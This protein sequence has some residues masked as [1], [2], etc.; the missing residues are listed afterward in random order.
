MFAI[1]KIFRG[2]ICALFVLTLIAYNFPRSQSLRAET[3]LRVQ[4]CENKTVDIAKLEAAAAWID[5]N[6]TYI[7]AFI[8]RRCGETLIERYF[9]NYD[10]ETR[11]DL[12][13]ATKTVT[14]ALI[15]IALHDGVIESVDQ[16]LS[17]LLP[18]YAGLLLDEKASITLRHV[19]TM[20]SG[21]KWV[22]FGSDRSF[23][24]M[25]AATDSVEW[26]LSQPLQTKPGE[27]FFYNTGSSHLLS[28]IIS[29][30]TGMSAAAYAEEKLFRPL[31][32]TDYE[33]GAHPDGVN[34][35]GWQLYL[36]PRGMAKFGQLYLDEGVWNGLRL[37]GADFISEATRKHNDTDYQSGYGW[38]MW[39]EPGFGT[40]DV[41]G[42]R[43]WGGQDIFILDEHDAVVVFTGNI[44]HP[45]EMAEHNHLLMSNYV[46]P[47]LKKAV[48]E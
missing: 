23:D 36:R 21:L 19:L 5:A 12:Q 25:D 7:D 28:A 2:L 46:V 18:N 48:L 1:S 16:S 26:I 38:Q 47:A 4:A 35:G 17:T 42:A 32:I 27:T 43:G 3:E 22:D 41:A 11:H 31:G 14:A 20:T 24:Q 6:E 8:V 37:M 10:A 9:N 30:N 44:M 39:I 13:S 34:Q 29:Y 40:P 15:G 33:W 45:K